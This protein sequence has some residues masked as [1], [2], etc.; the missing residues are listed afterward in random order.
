[1]YRR[2][3]TSLVLAAALVPP[4]HARDA[5]GKEIT[6]HY[7]LHGVR[8]T[9]SELLLK[10][11]GRF[12]WY[13]TYGAVDQ[14]ARGTW[15]RKGDAVTLRAEGPDRSKPL[16]RP[17]EQV[18]WDMSHEQALLDR[19][20]AEAYAEMEKRC[21]LQQIGLTAS[22][23]PI[24]TEPPDKAA[25]KAKADASVVAEAKTRAAAEA[26]A[27]SAITLLNTPGADARLDVATKAISDWQ[28]ASHEMQNAFEAAGLT[29]PHRA[30]L[31]LP[32][33]C[34]P[35]PERRADADHPDLRQGG[36]IISVADPQMG[37][38][39]QGVTVT[40][41]YADGSKATAKTARRGWAIF[42]RRKGSAARHV[43]LE[44][45]FAP[46]GRA[47][48]EIRPMEKGLQAI[49]MDAQQLMAAPFETMELRVEGSDLVPFDMGRGRYVREGR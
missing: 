41:T 40:V 23:G 4:L 10:P 47:E 26:A 36:I 34:D 9:G 29:T 37:I 22:P 48:F 5:S 20:R 45:E 32:A 21:P 39:P 31:R 49:A 17:D 43:A 1:M 15:L 16:F 8:E 19:A 14:T 25:L 12:E 3:A 2:L 13:M 28:V 38:A 7:Y 6:G 30:E 11:D 44:A 18:P 35:P 24:A 42:D 33:A 46:R 27:A